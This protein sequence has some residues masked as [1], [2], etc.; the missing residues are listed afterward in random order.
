M[1]SYMK[2]TTGAT[3]ARPN[4][5]EDFD[6][7]ECPILARHWFGVP[8]PFAPSTFARIDDIASAEVRRLYW[9]L[10]AQGVELPAE[11]GMILIDGGRP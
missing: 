11:R 9:R 10:R 8:P 4:I 5:P 7:A 6:P 3:A 1:N 2:T